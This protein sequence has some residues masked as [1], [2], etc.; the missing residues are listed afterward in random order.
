[1][2]NILFL[3]LLVSVI[4]DARTASAQRAECPA[5]KQTVYIARN[6]NDNMAQAVKDAVSQPNRLVLLEPDFDIDFTHMSD[7]VSKDDTQVT[8]IL[9]ARCVTLASFQPMPLRW[10]PPVPG[11]GRTPHSLG[12]VLRLGKG[13]IDRKDRAAFIGMGCDV[14]TGGFVDSDGA[15]ILGIRI[16]GPGIER[17]DNQRGINIHGCHD[18]EIAN[19]ELAGWGEA[20]IQVDD[21]NHVPGIPNQAP[22]ELLIRIHDNYI[23]H[24]QHPTENNSAAGYGVDM[25]RGA[26]AEI[27]QNV[28]DYNRHSITA[29]GYSGG[30]NAL[31][32]LILKGGG[33]HGGTFHTYVHVIDVHGTADCPEFTIGEGADLGAVIGGLLG[34]PWG[35]QIGGLIGGT[36]LTDASHHWFNCGDAGFQFLISQNTIQYSKTTELKIRG[37]PKGPQ[38]A[39]ITNNIFER[40]KGPIVLQH[41]FDYVHSDADQ[42]AIVLQTDDQV[43]VTGSNKYDDDTFGH[44]GVCDIDGDGID[45]LVLM[46]GVTWWF[47]SSGQFQWSFLKVDP[48]VLKDV[49]LGDVDG[50]GRCDVIKDV[51]GG[52][53]MMASGATG[54]WKPFGNFLASLNEVRFG[55]FDPAIRDHRQGIRPPTHAFWRNNV[56]FWFVTP[57]PHPN[58]WTFIQSSSFPL[59][60]LRFGDFTGDGVTDVL[61]NQGDHWSFSD[62]A[63]ATWAP[64]N[65]TLNDP[66]KNQNIFIANMDANDNFDD[67]LR[68]DTKGGPVDVTTNSAVLTATW[69]RSMNGR[70]PWTQF[71]E[72]GFAVDISKPSQEYAPLQFGF[73]GHFSGDPGASILTIDVNRIGHFFNSAHANDPKEWTGLFPY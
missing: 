22:T 32:N 46:T 68:L 18:V 35:A 26:F 49:Q 60:D 72:Y 27:Q 25:G 12:P 24:N 16:I 64:L 52:N 62:A 6:Q 1:M 47:S 38:G 65:P 19:S 44:Y 30:Y 36:S 15:R 57:L 9:F 28:F 39:I 70:T 55:R 37:R 17:Q 59:A 53:W 56:G 20:A 45:D 14:D 48:A 50:D 31:R 54:D 40:P 69:Q 5:T 61:S 73:V 67:I 34:G 21:S 8:I 33:F 2:R 42:H 63:R 10:L 66:V 13:K 23:H 51:G 71:K 3:A 29:S 11:S 41:W 7:E 4:G 58:L 43:I